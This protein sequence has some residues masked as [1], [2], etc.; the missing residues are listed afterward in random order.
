MTLEVPA[1]VSDEARIVE[2]DALATT[3]RVEALV[4]L[5]VCSHYSSVGRD[6][7]AT[8]KRA[9]GRITAD[10]RPIE[11]RIAALANAETYAG[12]LA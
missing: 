6:L 8:L 7:T 11:H 4:R 12:V 5:L 2:D 3:H 1:D 10:W 9:A